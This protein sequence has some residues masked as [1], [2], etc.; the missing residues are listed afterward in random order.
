MAPVINAAVKAG[1]EGFLDAGNAEH[2]RRAYVD[3]TTT[4]LVFILTLVIL[5]FVGKFLWNG[6]IVDL[7]SFAKPARSVW[8]ILGLMIFVSL[9]LN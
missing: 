2:R 4:L 3:F 8:Q 7:F 9:L 6:V 1:V 5:G